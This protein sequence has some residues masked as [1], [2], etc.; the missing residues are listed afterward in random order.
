[1]GN[2]VDGS[3]SFELT[4]LEDFQPRYRSKGSINSPFYIKLYKFS[5]RGSHDP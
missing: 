4:I 2:P 1:M 3:F 5:P